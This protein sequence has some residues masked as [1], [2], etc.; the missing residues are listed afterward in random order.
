[1]SAATLTQTATAGALPRVN[2]LPP[3]IAE[4]R[5]LRQAEL[6]A[7]GI[8]VAALLA[9]GGLYYQAH[10]EVT[11]ANA[12][13]T[14]TQAAGAGLRAQIAHYDFVTRTRAQVQQAQ[15]ALDAAMAGQV[16]WSRYLDDLSLDIPDNVW[17]TSMTLTEQP[18]G[19]VTAAPN[20]FTPGGVATVDFTGVAFTADDVATWLDSLAKIP[21]FADPAFSSYT[22]GV[23]AG[24]QTVT[25]TSS[26][27]VTSAAL[28]QRFTSNAGR[29]Q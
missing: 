8:V 26:V 27:V 1:M 23:I 7:V 25:F 9:V 20:P 24:H 29:L 5:R 17:L 6:G 12:T 16:L 11:R 2:L 13:L 15:S 3:E 21:G 4:A 22:T 19:A 18:G 14:A 10:G 28:S